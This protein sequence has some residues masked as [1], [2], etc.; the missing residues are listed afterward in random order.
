MSKP[1][2][3]DHILVEQD[4]YAFWKENNFFEPIAKTDRNKNYSVILPPPNI[5]GR[6]HLGHA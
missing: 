6:L 1:L 4:L 2:I 5:T 3:Y